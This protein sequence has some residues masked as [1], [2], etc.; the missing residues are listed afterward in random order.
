MLFINMHFLMDPILDMQIRG[1]ADLL[2]DSIKS[3]HL[4]SQGQNWRVKSTDTCRENPLKLVHTEL[5]I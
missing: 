1:L 5:G 3:T 2:L 4:Y